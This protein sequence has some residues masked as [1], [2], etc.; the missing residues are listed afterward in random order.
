MSYLDNGKKYPMVRQFGFVIND[1]YQHKCEN[2]H[3]VCRLIK[4][5][6]GVVS[7]LGII[8]AIPF[9]SSVRYP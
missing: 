6:R 8:L 3:G 9:F 7:R 4:Y 2:R 5:I 1:C